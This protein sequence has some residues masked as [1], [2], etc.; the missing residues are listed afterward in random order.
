[1]TMSNQ[2]ETDLFHYLETIPDPRADINK[3]HNLIDVVFLTLCAVLSGASG[4]KSIQEFGEEQLDWLREYR[5]FENGIP[6]RHCIANIIKALESDLLIQAVFSWINQ[7]REKEGKSIIALDGKTMRRAWDDDIQKALHVVSAFDVG[8]GITLF[9]GDSDKKGKEAEVTRKIFDTLTL[10]NAIVTLDALHCQIATMKKI[11]SKKGDFVIQ[12][13]K[14]QPRLLEAVQS[15]FS[16][17]YEDPELAT[18]EQKNKGHGRKECRRVMQIDADLTPDLRK[19]WPHIKTLIEVAVERTVG[20]ATS[21]SSRW[22]VSS[23]PVDVELVSG[24]VREHWSI[25]NNLH[26]VLDVVFREDELNVSDP[27]GARHLAM[28]N[29]AALSVLKQHTGKKDS[30]AGKRRRAAWSPSFRSELLFG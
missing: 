15:A 16:D 28:F 23:L 4:W 6:R 10:D 1:M 20:G 26:W 24:I 9:Q 30:M 22:Y 19:K 11:I 2:S 3:K 17:H 18:F 12:L 5:A 14:N 25:E 13:K 29:R 27:D 7:R 21:C 8:K